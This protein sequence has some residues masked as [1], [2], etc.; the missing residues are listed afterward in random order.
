M[1]TA[2]GEPDTIETARVRLRPMRLGDLDDVAALLG[3]PRVM[4][5]FP[6]PR[7]RAEAAAWIERY[8]AR[9]A[10]HGFGLWTMESLDGE[11]LGDC[12]L[13]LQPVGDAEMLEVGYRVKSA[14]Q[15][16]GFATEAAAACVDY[17][18]EHALAPELVAIIHHLNR[19]SIRVAEK[20]GMR[21]AP[22]L[23]HASPFHVVYAMRL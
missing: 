3:D 7:T 19:P 11:F 15:G 18:R 16:R 8:L 14:A 21:K 22:H 20:I 17:A 10:T 1:M 4:Q 2:H 23:R 9:Y 5:Y 6:L 12:G 13:T